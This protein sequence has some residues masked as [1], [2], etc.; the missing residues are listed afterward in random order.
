MA[1]ITAPETV[2]TPPSSTI[3][4]AS[5]ESEIPRLSGKTLPLRYANSAPATPATVPAITKAVHWMRLPSM[6]IASL[7]SGESRGARKRGH[8]DRQ[9]VK[10]RRPRR[11]LLGPDAEDAVVAAGHR[12]PLERD[13]PDDLRECQRQHCEIHAG[14]LNREEP[15]HRST[16]HSQYRAEQKRDDHRQAGEL[17]EER[18]AIGAEPE[19]RRMTE[20]GE[21]ANRHQKVQARGK[22]HKDRN[23]RTNR[24]S[25]IAA[26]QRQGRRRHQRGK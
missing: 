8:A 3:T 16:Q 2:S 20:R 24:E 23:L 15:E 4:R 26:D 21:P 19:I 6:P 13:R 25:I 9:P 11:P 10:I 7:R 5:T 12:D 18:D 14:Q 17:G 1:P 22:N